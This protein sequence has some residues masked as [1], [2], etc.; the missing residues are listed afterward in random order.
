MAALLHDLVETPTE[1]IAEDYVLSRIGV[2]KER[3]ILTEN[4]K[5]WLGEEAMN[6]PGVLELASVS[7][8][9]MEAFIVTLHRR[10]GGAKGYLVDGLGFSEREVETIIRNIRI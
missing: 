10:F 4:L 3:K 8:K 7:L 6:Q 2:E 1:V 5:K 9:V